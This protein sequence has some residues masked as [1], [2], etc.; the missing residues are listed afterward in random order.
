M[1]KI[2][3]VD[4]MK[5]VV[6]LDDGTTLGIPREDVK[7]APFVGQDVKIF[8]DGEKNYIAPQN[9]D[10]AALTAAS[11]GKKFVNKTT[12][13]LLAFFLGGFGAHKFYQGKTGT[14]ILYLLFCWTTIPTIAAFIEFIIA[15]TK[16]SDANGNIVM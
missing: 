5:V 14:G 7:F 8:Q 13:A 10:T 12:Y 1:A 2:V 11:K 3:A 6:G 4:G 9:E 16:P 15:L